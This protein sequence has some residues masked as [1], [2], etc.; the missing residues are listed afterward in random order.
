MH[1]N[2][3]SYS[4]QGRFLRGKVGKSGGSV[5]GRVFPSDGLDYNQTYPHQHQSSGE[6]VPCQVGLAKNHGAVKDADQQAKPFDSDHIGGLHLV[7][8]HEVGDH[9]D[10]HEGG[11]G[12][13]DKGMAG[14]HPDS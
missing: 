7:H 12:E 14:K 13:I 9:H 5:G 2:T 6:Q 3:R 8:R 11:D 10:C 1:Y 4:Y